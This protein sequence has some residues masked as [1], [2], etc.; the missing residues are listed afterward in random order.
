MD[1]IGHRLR[2]AFLVTTRGDFLKGL[3][4][5]WDVEPKCSVNPRDGWR[6]GIHDA[7][8]MFN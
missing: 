2:D 1:N 6:D 4:D 7:L 8:L 3:A 5:E